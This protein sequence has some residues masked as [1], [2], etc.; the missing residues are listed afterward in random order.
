MVVTYQDILRRRN[1][2]RA[3][4]SE[5]GSRPTRPEPDDEQRAK[6]RKYQKDWRARRKAQRSIDNSLT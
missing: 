3:P 2:K 6:W 5:A 4:A 1:L